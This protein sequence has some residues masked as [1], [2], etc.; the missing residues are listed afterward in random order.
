[1]L[2]QSTKITILEGAAVGN[3]GNAFD[4]IE[5]WMTLDQREMAVLER[6]PDFLAFASSNP[7]ILF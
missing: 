1:M 5:V 7:P 6:D 2:I 3:G 4:E